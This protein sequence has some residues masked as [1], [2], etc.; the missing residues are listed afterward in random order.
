[1]KMMPGYKPDLMNNKLV[2]AGND[3]IKGPYTSYAL[4]G[5]EV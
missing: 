4:W 3:G 1:M 5:V 2:E